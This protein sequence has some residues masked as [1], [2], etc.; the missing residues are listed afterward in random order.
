MNW[1]SI[2]AVAISALLFILN[3]T[4]SLINTKN[5]SRKEGKEEGYTQGLLKSIDERTSNMASEQK[6]FFRE[7]RTSLKDIDNRLCVVEE[8][9]HSAHNRIDKLEGG[10]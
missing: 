5:S 2:L 1:V 9:V 8:R 6:D 3:F 4:V 7:T 10:K